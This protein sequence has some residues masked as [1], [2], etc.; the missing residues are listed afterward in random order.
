M[1]L[2]PF[3]GASWV[4]KPTM[5]APSPAPRGSKRQKREGKERTKKTKKKNT[6][7]EVN[8]NL[9]SKGTGSAL[10]RNNFFALSTSIKKKK[11]KK[12][13]KNTTT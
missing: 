10:K 11:H 5:L 4:P 8:I 2:T 1:I 7:K 13:K 3:W 9:F 6:K 12:Y